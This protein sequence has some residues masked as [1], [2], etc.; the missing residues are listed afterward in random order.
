MAEKKEQKNKEV[1]APKVKT[2]KTKVKEKV[3]E[4]KIP[5]RL[6]NI[7]KKE[8]VPALMKKFNYKSIMQVPKLSKIVINMGVGSAASDSKVLEEAIKNLETIS[9]Q[10][11]SVRIAKKAISNFKLREGMKIGTMVTL[12]RDKMFEFLDRLI[13]VALPR[14]RDFRGLSDKSF[15]G[16]GNYTIGIKEQII[17]PEIDIDKVNKVLG[18]DITFVTT[19]KTDSESFELLMAFGVPFVKKEV[20]SA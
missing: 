1:K 13:N 7:Y 15:D 14:V 9:G 16:R 2:E 19:A 6:E 4:I 17:F 11:S 10:K 18:M 3:A 12:R 8:I 20:K 5:V